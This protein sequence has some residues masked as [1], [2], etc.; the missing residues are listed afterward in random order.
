MK[1]QFDKRRSL[2][3]SYKEGDLVWL[4]GTNI[5]G[6][7]VTKKLSPWRYGPFA[8][9]EKIGQGAYR[10][11]LPDG[12]IIHDVF[13]EALLTPHKKPSFKIQDKPTPPP[14]EI[15]NEEEEYEVEEIRGHRQRGRGTQYL[16]HWKGYNNEEDTWIAES[17]LPHAQEAIDEYHKRFPEKNRIKRGAKNPRKTSKPSN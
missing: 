5:V 17:Q 16:V 3:R 15:I 10:L 11:K 2:A 7:Q 13:N 9:K 4:E 6:N 14:P 12:W 8:I 1:E